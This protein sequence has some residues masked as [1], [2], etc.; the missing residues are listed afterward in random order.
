[1]DIWDM[2]FLKNTPRFVIR[3]QD[4]SQI[5]VGQRDRVNTRK[6]NLVIDESEAR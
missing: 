6:A 2:N 5:I 3:I 4:I 1:M